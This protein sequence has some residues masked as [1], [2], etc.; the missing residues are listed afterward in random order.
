MHAGP[1][2][3]DAKTSKKIRLASVRKDASETLWS[4]SVVSNAEGA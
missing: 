1:P 3:F 2:A 4:R